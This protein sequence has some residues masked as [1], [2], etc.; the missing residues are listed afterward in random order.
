MIVDLTG[1]YPL[2]PYPYRKRVFR[3]FVLRSYYSLMHKIY[4]D[5]INR[6]PPINQVELLPSYDKGGAQWITD[7]QMQ[8]RSE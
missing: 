5:L 1:D 3:T 7:T 8:L 4:T 2:S 6:S